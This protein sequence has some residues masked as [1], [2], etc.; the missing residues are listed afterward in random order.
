MWMKERNSGLIRE[1][2]D[3]TPFD[4]A[5]F[6]L[7]HVEQSKAPEEPKKKKKKKH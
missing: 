3:G 2:P 6:K 5:F 1:V 7:F 4:E